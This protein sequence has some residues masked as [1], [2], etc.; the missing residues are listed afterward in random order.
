MGAGVAGRRGDR[1]IRSQNLRLLFMTCVIV[2]V[3]PYR[4]V[5]FYSYFKICAQYHNK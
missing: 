5:N 4:I 1:V 2:A 3:A